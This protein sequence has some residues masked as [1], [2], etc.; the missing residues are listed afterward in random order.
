MNDLIPDNQRAMICSCGCAS[1]ILRG[2][3]FCECVGCG[4]FGGM[5]WDR[6]NGELADVCDD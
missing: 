2:D 3:G 4:L 6:Y 5:S 1:Y